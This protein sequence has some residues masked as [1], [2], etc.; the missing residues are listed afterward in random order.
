MTDSKKS[1]DAL[2]P[3]ERAACAPSG[4]NGF[5]E[6]L[7]GGFP[8]E[9]LHL[10]EGDPGTGKTTL[11]LQF[12]LEGQRHG[13]AGMYVTFTETAAQLRRNAQSHGWSLDGLTI[14]EMGAPAEALDP[15]AEYSF[16]HPSDVELSEL[17]KAIFGTFGRAAPKRLVLDAL[18]EVRL[19]AREPI[20]FRREVLALKQ[21]FG[22]AGCTVLFLDDRTSGSGQNQ[23]HSLADSVT[24]LEQAAPGYGAQPRRLRVVKVRGVDFRSGYHDF[25][26]R[27]G[28]LQVFPRLVA[29]EYRSEV[30]LSTVDSGLP[31]LD[32]LLG[33][34]LARGTNTLVIGPAGAGKSVIATQYAVAA[35]S[36]GERTAI[37]LF[38]ERPPTYIARAT[39]LGMRLADAL[40]G[41]RITLQ[42]L[43]PAELTP[44][45]FAHVVRAA[46]KDGTQFVIVDSLNGY[47]QSAPEER[48]LLLH[49]HEL[50]AF[51]GQSGV[52]TILTVAE[53]GVTGDAMSAPIDVA[54]LADTVLLL[55][56][57]EA[58]GAIRRALSVLK[59]RHG[60]HEATIRELSLNAN[61]IHIGEP[62][63]DFHGVLTGAPTLVAGRR[64]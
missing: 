14:H 28:G 53:H 24:I 1:S 47:L 5:D 3:T 26:I 30:L 46:I 63:S 51:L 32:A 12:L 50:L 59:K 8:R 16:F 41:G 61:G 31:A 34:G 19:L 38:D 36:R 54:Y 49:L 17:T 25:A 13:E 35:A 48:Q 39:G 60:G 42:Q 45:Q 9:Q 33:D 2:L 43:D 7:L 18:A 27:L 20:R 22:D 62:L 10:I 37:Y 57:F 21:F 40:T 58:G 23:L 52:T 15:D 56:Y 29:A 55:R 64:T 6:I 4:V 44:G 11:G